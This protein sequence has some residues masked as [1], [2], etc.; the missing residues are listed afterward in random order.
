MGC[1]VMGVQYGSDEQ[2]YVVWCCVSCVDV[3]VLVVGIV[4]IGWYQY[5]VIINVVGVDDGMVQYLVDLVVLQWYFGC[6]WYMCLLFRCG[7][8][9]IVYVYLQGS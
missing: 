6:V 1:I 7:K 5:F 3:D 2:F 8:Q 4:V 9:D